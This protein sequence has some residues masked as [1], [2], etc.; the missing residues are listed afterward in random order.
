M[1]RCSP[2]RRSPAPPPRLPRNPSSVPGVLAA[3]S[4]SDSGVRIPIHPRSSSVKA[5][6]ALHGLLHQK[7]HR[8]NAAGGRPIPAPPF[9]G[10]ASVHRPPRAARRLGGGG[11]PGLGPR[12]RR[13]S[14]AA[15]SPPTPPAA[16]ASRRTPGAQREPL[17][18][19]PPGGHERDPP[20]SRLSPSPEQVRG[21]GGSQKR[22]AAPAVAADLGQ[23]PHSNVVS[24]S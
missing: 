3:D 9:K 22:I 17:L 6:A 4:A 10:P 2:P 13:E 15:R 14:D 21:E 18:R 16:L 11:S 7:R 5:L 8:A 24:I 12:R 1:S 19:P 20:A 23:P